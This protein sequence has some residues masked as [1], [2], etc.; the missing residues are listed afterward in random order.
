MPIPPK[1]EQ[2]SIATHIDVETKDIDRLIGE[3]EQLTKL[4]IREGADAEKLRSISHYDGTP[5]RPDAVVSFVAN[6]I[7]QSEVAVA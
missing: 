1:D 4:L 2:K 3:A 6:D 7:Q 5:I